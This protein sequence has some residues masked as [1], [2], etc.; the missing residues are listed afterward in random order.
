MI[1]LVDASKLKHETKLFF[2]RTF[3]LIG[4]FLISSKSNQLDELPYNIVLKVGI[5]K[6]SSLMVPKQR[7][8]TR[9]RVPHDLLNFFTRKQC[10]LRFLAAK[11]IC[12]LFFF[13]IL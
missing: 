2:K 13:C 12:I 3:T 10:G 11:F 7:L 1:C 6:Q 4:L 5:C 8:M 9:R